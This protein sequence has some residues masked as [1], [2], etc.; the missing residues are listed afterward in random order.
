ME[1]L[2]KTK[3]AVDPTHSE[4]AFKAK[5]LMITNVSG[6]FQEYDIDVETEGDDFSTAKISFHAQVASITTANEQRDAHLKSA[7]FFD[8]QNHPLLSFQS[9]AFEKGKNEEEFLLH[10]HISI[11]G[12]VKPITLIVEYGGIITDPY[13]N[14]KAGFTLNGKI[15]RKDFG[16]SWNAVTEA[17]SI[18]VSDEIKI[19]C[20]VQLVKQA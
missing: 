9:T 15:N 5:H 19:N 6:S 2:T 7:D 17:G 13:G 12:I 18:V 1:S 14:E 4:I 10:G 3:W 16:L 8:V 11:R 20:E